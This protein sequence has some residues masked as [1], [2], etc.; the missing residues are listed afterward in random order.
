[1]ADRAEHSSASDQELLTRHVDG[2][3]DAF[4]E[5]VRR[6]R[7]RLWAVA[8]RTLGDRE[9]A[10]DA[11]QDALVSAYR[12]AHT[13]RGQS[14]VTT[15][16]HR[17][18]VNAC[19]DRARKAASRKTAPVDDTERLEQLLEPHESASAPAERN[20]LHRQ[21]LAALST[22]PPDQRAAL[23]LVD[24]QGYPVAE[25]ARIL[26]VPTGTVKSRCARGRARLLPLLTHLRPGSGDDGKK[27]GEER[28]RTQEASV[29]PA[30]GPPRAEPPRAGPSDSAAVKGGGGRA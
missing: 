3:P 30:A 24:M 20:D 12:A 6:H 27:P 19:L 4:G 18:T 28:N 9:E 2:D 11:V 26:D 23:V 25:A 21:L 10:A 8:L 17:I 15:W 22:L 7:D 14:A 1:M 5:L 29:P 16:L 13:F